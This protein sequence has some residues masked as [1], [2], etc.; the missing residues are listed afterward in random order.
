MRKWLG[1]IG[2]FASV[3]FL[4]FMLIAME[5]AGRISWDE[6]LPFLLFYTGF[7]FFVSL[8]AF[9]NGDQEDAKDKKPRARI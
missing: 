4:G 7:S 2:L 8:W 6:F 9:F 1:W 5:S 3:S